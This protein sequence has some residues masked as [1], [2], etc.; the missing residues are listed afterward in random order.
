MSI[1]KAF[2][3]RVY[4]TPAQEA[5][6]ERWENALRWLW[7]LANEQRWMGLSRCKD[8]KIYVRYAQQNR[9]LTVLRAEYPWLKDVPSNLCQ[10]VLIDLDQAWRRYFAKL[11]SPPKYKSRRFRSN[12]ALRCGPECFSLDA[13]GVRNFV[14]LG[15]LRT[16]LHRPIEGRP[17][18]CALVAEAD[19]WFVSVTCEIASEL[20]EPQRSSPIVGVARASD[21]FYALSDGQVVTAEPPKIA[22]TAAALARTRRTVDRRR[23]GSKRRERAEQREMRLACK[24]KRQR[25]HTLHVESK[26]IAES[27]GIVVIEKLDVTRSHFVGWPTFVAMLRYKVQW[28]GGIFVEVIGGTERETC[29]NC[30]HRQRPKFWSQQFTCLNCGHEQAASVNAAVNLRARGNPS[31]LHVDGAYRRPRKKRESDLQP[32]AVGGELT[33]SF[34]RS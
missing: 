7:N 9:D 11:G 15:R 12:I 25:A 10:S 19:Q 13:R 3:F 2:R 28:A 1:Y 17:K 31:C 30:G 8:D 16:I 26:R 29:S 6:L 32:P 33:G 24:A 34:R 20:P 23:P 21:G 5:R 4:L 14:K 27:Q 22:R 18:T